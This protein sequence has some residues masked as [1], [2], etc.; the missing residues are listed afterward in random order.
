MRFRVNEWVG[1]TKVK[2][3]GRS[4]LFMKEHMVNEN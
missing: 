4:L 2:G 3:L 1:Y